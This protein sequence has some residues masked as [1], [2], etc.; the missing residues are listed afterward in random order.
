MQ[1]IVY[2]LGYTVFNVNYNNNTYV[3]NERINIH[4]YKHFKH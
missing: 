4:N 2:P 1:H 3:N